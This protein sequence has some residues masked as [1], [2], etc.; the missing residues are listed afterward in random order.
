MYLD[1]DNKL[2]LKKIN[3]K[4]INIKILGAAIIVIIVILLLTFSI[5]TEN[6]ITYKNFNQIKMNEDMESVEK[7]IG[8]DYTSVSDS[9]GYNKSGQSAFK[10]EKDKDNFIVLAINHGKVFG[11]FEHGLNPKGND[12]KEEK[13]EQVTKGDSLTNVKNRLGDGY[14]VCEEVLSNNEI[15]SE[16][17]WNIENNK[18][19]YVQ[20]T[21]KVVSKVTLE[22][23][24]DYTNSSKD[25]SGQE[26]SSIKQEDSKQKV[27]NTNIEDK[28]VVEAPKDIT[29]P[30]TFT[31][32]QYSDPIWGY[33]ISYPTFLTNK[34]KSNNSIILKSND[35]SASLET[36]VR[37]NVNVSIQDEYADR[38]HS[39]NGAGITY[40][41]LGERSFSISYVNNNKGYYMCEILKNNTVV[42]FNFT[43]P[44]DKLSTYSDIIQKVYDSFNV[45]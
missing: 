18:V 43:F 34:E 21:D 39:V 16:Y 13:T 36:Y 42:G 20:F 7:L 25:S 23:S 32:A 26:A 45:I 9:V 41:Y 14:L 15:L 1:K 22:N 33:D 28:K 30:G 3:K 40:K 29:E 44:I 19:L 35:S 17:I 5:L 8:E 24:K 2:D 37:E 10:W 27:T 11:K 6:K 4:N 31:Y 38:L 12:V